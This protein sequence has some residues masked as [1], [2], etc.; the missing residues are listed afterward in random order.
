MIRIICP[1]CGTQVLVKDLVLKE[2]QKGH[3]LLDKCS[4][5]GAFEGGYWDECQECVRWIKEEDEED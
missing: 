2:N 5:P 4:H 1:H 3:C